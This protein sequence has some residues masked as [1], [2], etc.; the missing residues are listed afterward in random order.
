MKRPSLIRIAIAATT[1]SLLVLTGC[2]SSPSTDSAPTETSEGAFPVTIEHA[3]GETVIPSEPKR[4][5]AWGWGS[6]DAALALDVVPVAIPFQSYG[7]NSDGV[8]PWI[9]E[10]LDSLGADTPTVLPDTTEAP[11]EEI[12]AAKP[13]LILAT[14]SGLTKDE[15]DLLSAIAPVV[16]YPGEPWATPWRDLITTTGEALGKHH[17]AVKVVE[18]IDA[19]VAA[20]AAK[21]PEFEGVTIA[22]VWDFSGKF[23]VHTPADPRVE[24]TEDLGFKTATSVTELDTGESTFFYTLSHEKLDSLTSDL[25]ISYA[26]T[27]EDSDAF[28]ASSPAQAMSQV[29][30]NRVAQVVGK[31]FIASVS[32]PTALSLTWGLDNY[33]DILAQ[34]VAASK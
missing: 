10:K 27:Q 15:Y 25:L 31:D 21:H 33:V 14:Y 24:F 26:D 18:D 29:T 20:Q 2:S 28:L 9:E 34:A 30:E 32:P 1:A 11:V 23:Y 17:E 16:A 13:D 12:L 8:L 7:G 19:Q 22:Q 3:F 4:V 6:A 5:V